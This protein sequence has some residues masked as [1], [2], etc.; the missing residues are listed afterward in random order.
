MTPE[1]ANTIADDLR[2][3]FDCPVFVLYPGD[4]IVGGDER[5]VTIY[6]AV[7]DSLITHPL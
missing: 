3:A 1:E 6:N 7:S 2:L 5:Q 4:E